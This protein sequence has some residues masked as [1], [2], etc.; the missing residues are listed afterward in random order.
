MEV[1]LTSR[2]VKR[3]YYD[4]VAVPCHR[5]DWNLDPDLAMTCD[6]PQVL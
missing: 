2:I 4:A 1:T 5:N 3:K 6:F